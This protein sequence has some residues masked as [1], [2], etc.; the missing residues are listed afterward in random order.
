MG[1]ADGVGSAHS[2]LREKFGKDFHL[3]QIRGYGWLS[4]VG[5]CASVGDIGTIAATM[6]G[7]SGAP[8]GEVLGDAMWQA[9]EH[10]MDNE[11]LARYGV[12][13]R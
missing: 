10:A 6:Q 5:S 11:T 4:S 13:H 7:S 2:I 1:L 3:Q 9:M 8:S 12:R